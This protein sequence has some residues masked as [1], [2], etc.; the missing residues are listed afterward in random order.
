M[1]TNFEPVSLAKG[2]ASPRPS[3]LR[4]R[5]SVWYY[6]VPIKCCI[7]LAVTFVV[8]FPKPG[9]FLRHVGHSRNLDAMVEPD[10]PELAMWDAELE[11]R[12]LD[13]RGRREDG[14]DAAKPVLRTLSPHETQREVQQFVYAKV[15][16]DWDWNVWG[17][18]DYLPTV[19]EMFAMAAEREDG[20]IYEDCDGRAVMA[21]S[22]MRRLGY[23]SHLVTDLRHMWV[24]TSQGD[25]MGPGRKETIV[26]TRDGNKIIVGTALQNFMASLP[27]GIAVFP[28]WR[29]IIIL[30]AAY[31]LILH[32]R[33][34]W[35]AAGLGGLLLGQGLMFMQCGVLSPLR[36]SGF[37][38][39]WPSWV[40]MAHALAGFALLFVA[41]RRA[42]RSVGRRH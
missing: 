39:Q 34:S 31:V 38:V 13:A 42:R 23:D 14:G 28:L 33:M 37:G 17:S 16:Y 18:A 4:R 6:R 7:F 25:W 36:L 35:R 27:Y 21:A 40:G 9:Q 1:P 15:K 3:F 19:A 32:R 2:G 41:S 12:L 22:L 30:L 20:Q 26:S 8:L 24:K 11:R 29:E 10:A 5:L